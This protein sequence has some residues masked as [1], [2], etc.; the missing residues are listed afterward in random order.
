MSRGLLLAVGRPDG[1]LCCLSKTEDSIHLALK[2]AY[3]IQ[4][5]GYPMGVKTGNAPEIFSVGHNP[6]KQSYVHTHVVL[7]STRRPFLDEIVYDDMHKP[8]DKVTPKGVLRRI[9]AQLDGQRRVFMSSM[10]LLARGESVNALHSLDVNGWNKLPFGSHYVLPPAKVDLH[11]TPGDFLVRRRLKM[12]LSTEAGD[13]YNQPHRRLAFV[14]K[15][16][17]RTREVQDRQ[18]VIQRFY[19]CRVDAPQRYL[20]F[21]VAF[22]AMAE[23]SSRPWFRTR[24]IVGRSQS[25]L[26]IA[27]TASPIAGSDAQREVEHVGAEV[28][29][30]V[31]TVGNRIRGFPTHF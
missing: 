8:N 27:T 26:R 23:R 30:H 10:A 29:L 28:R 18:T 17:S 19:E 11:D 1:R 15:L 25:N 14:E 20:A 6:A 2:Q 5:R 24:W 31:R 16:D 9:A 12:A 13:G 22:H 7:P 21:C 3:F 4:N